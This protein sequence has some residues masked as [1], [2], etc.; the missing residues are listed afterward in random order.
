LITQNR[1]ET[2]Y[3]KTIGN[4]GIGEARFNILMGQIDEYKKDDK[5]KIILIEEP[6]AYLD[7]E[8]QMVILKSLGKLA[9]TKQ[10]FIS[11]HSPY[12]INWEYLQNGSTIIKM[13][14]NDNETLAGKFCDPSIAGKIKNQL[15]RNPHLNGVE[16]KNIFFSNKVFVVEGQVDVGLITKY[17]IGSEYD[18]IFFGYGSG[19]KDRIKLILKVCSDLKIPKVAALLDNNLSDNNSAYEYCNYTFGNYYKIEKLLAD[20][21]CDKYEN[22]QMIKSGAFDEHGNLKANELGNDFSKKIQTILDYFRAK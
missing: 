11:T 14:R 10:I 22:G 1:N 3:P 8:N 18:F 21:I 2:F 4:S 9:I 12:L 5:I 19:G 15:P 6:E 13:N 17:L 7:P 20:D 16:T